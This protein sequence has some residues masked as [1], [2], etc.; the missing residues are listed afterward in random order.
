MFHA[1]IRGAAAGGAVVGGAAGIATV[2][3]GSTATVAGSI[4]G[5]VGGSAIATGLVCSGVGAVVGFG[6]A[7][8]ILYFRYKN[9]KS[10]QD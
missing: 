10:K 5:M 4:A 9:T 1:G 6:I 7:A 8:R 3:G 2:A